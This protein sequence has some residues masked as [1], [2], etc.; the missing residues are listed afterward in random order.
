MCA[1][2]IAYPSSAARSTPSRTSA[3]TAVRARVSVRLDALLPT[4]LWTA[5]E[6]LHAAERARQSRDAC[7]SWSWVFGRLRGEGHAPGVVK[8]GDDRPPDG[9]A[10]PS[11][12]RRSRQTNAEP[13]RER[14]KSLIRFLIRIPEKIP[15]PATPETIPILFVAAAFASVPSPTAARRARPR[16]TIAAETAAAGQFFGA[17]PEEVLHAILSRI[18]EDAFGKDD[19]AYTDASSA[20]TRED[21]RRGGASA[22]LAR[23]AATC[24]Y[25][26]DA[27]R[28]PR[29]GFGAVCTRT[30][31]TRCA[32]WWR[33][34]PAGWTR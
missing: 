30:N 18:G 22:N 28:E 6:R 20:P 1:R 13:R 11:P 31:A 2:A 9:P 17:V 12:R 3:S 32:R 26:R 10:G 25:L 4:S 7:A 5:G 21:E 15:H 19:T 29:R 16:E 14:Q 23:I 27:S 24:R 34:N 33:A 8:G